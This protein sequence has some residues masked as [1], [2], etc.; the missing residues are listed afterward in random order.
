M[1]LS[2]APEGQDGGPTDAIL[3]NNDDWLGRLGYVDF[4][5][6]IG[7]GRALLCGS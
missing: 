7:S 5:R 3:V 2:F 4:L 1:F 6:A